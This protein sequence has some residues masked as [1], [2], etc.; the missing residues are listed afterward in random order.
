MDERRCFSPQPSQVC[1]DCSGTTVQVAN[2]VKLVQ[3]A[4]PIVLST[5]RDSRGNPIILNETRTGTGPLLPPGTQSVCS[6]ADPPEGYPGQERRSRLRAGV[7]HTRPEI[8]TNSEL[9][10]VQ[11]FLIYATILKLSCTGE[12]CGI[13]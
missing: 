7:L 6:P 1:Q 12:I 10:S 11:N 13:L 3:P 4:P 5:R 2:V 8:I 9:Q